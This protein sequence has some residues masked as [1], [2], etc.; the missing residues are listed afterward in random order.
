MRA[1]H[2]TKHSCIIQVQD[3]TSRTREETAPNTTEGTVFALTEAE[4]LG[5]RPLTGRLQSLMLKDDFLNWTFLLAIR[6]ANLP[7]K[8]RHIYI[9]QHPRLWR[10][11]HHH[12]LILTLYLRDLQMTILL[13]PTWPTIFKS[14]AHLAPNI[15]FLS[16]DGHLVIQWGEESLPVIDEPTLLSIGALLQLKS[17]RLPLISEA[18]LMKLL[19]RLALL[20]K[21]ERFYSEHDSGHEQPERE[22]PFIAFPALR[23]LRWDHS[24]AILPHLFQSIQSPNFSSLYIAQRKPIISFVL[25][26]VLQSLTK[27]HGSTLASFIHHIPWFLWSRNRDIDLLQGHITIHI[28]QPLLDCQNLT[29]LELT[30]HI[31]VRLLPDDIQ[32]ICGSLLK[33]QSFKVATDIS[34][35]DGNPLLTTIDLQPFSHLPDL[36]RLF[37]QFDGSA[38]TADELKS[39]LKSTSKLRSFNVSISVPPASARDFVSAVKRMFP[40]LQLLSYET[41]TDSTGSDNDRFEDKPKTRNWDWDKVLFK[42]RSKREI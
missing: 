1:I 19:P 38:N 10:W 24:V 11:E 22:P 39:I 33:L 21:L 12:H 17:L 32:R 34:D 23:S 37:I 8:L 31:E 4:A 9:S 18:L 2:T 13:K 28:L 27:L 20:P 15:E 36:E 3:N 6:E 26:D 29:T 35:E 14:M 16:L 40:K 30:G 25:R 41:A 5:L 7:L 42:L